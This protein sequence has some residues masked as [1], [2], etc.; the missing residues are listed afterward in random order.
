MRR[1]FWLF[2]LL[3]CL[4]P[5]A[6]IGAALAVLEERPLVNRTVELTSDRLAQGERILDDNDPRKLQPGEIKTVRL[7]Q[8][9]LDITANYVVH[10]FA[11]GSALVRLRANVVGLSVTVPLPTPLNGRFVNIMVELLP[12]DS[13]LPAFES[14]KIGQINVPTRLANWLTAYGIACVNGQ[15]AVDVIAEAIKQLDVEPGLMTVIYQWQAD[16][17]ARLGSALVPPKESVRLLLYQQAMIQAGAQARKPTSLAV[18]LPPLF[19]LAAERSVGK[20]D[21]DPVAENRA[22][23]TVLTFYVNQR[24]L[25]KV[26]PNAEPWPKAALRT[27]KLNGRDDFP[28]HFILSAAIAITADSPLSDVIGLYKEVKDSRG[29]SGFSFNDL[30]A[31]RAGSRMGRWQAPVPKPRCICKRG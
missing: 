25:D 7:T 14:L 4:V 10:R 5:I 11:H 13:G 24:G 1:L 29:G 16:L 8:D 26:L 6:L 27:V 20:G 31:D 21:P 15:E 12:K 9:D 2:F 22:A 30:A 19:K 3:L 28:K 17:P 23:I 18:L